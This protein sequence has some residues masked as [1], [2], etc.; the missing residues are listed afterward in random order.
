MKEFENCLK[1]VST[2]LL[3]RVPELLPAKTQFDNSDGSMHTRC[4]NKSQDVFC[5][6]IRRN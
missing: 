2:L 4:S 3:Y 1:F 6:I 5:I